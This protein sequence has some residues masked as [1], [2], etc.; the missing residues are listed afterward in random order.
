MI[1]MKDIL[2]V[3]QH[4]TFALFVF[5]AVVALSSI[6]VFYVWLRTLARCAVRMDCSL[7]VLCRVRMGNAEMAIC[8]TNGF[9]HACGAHLRM[10]VRLNGFD[11]G[12]ERR[13]NACIY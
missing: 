4:K 6:Y 11:K 9:R 13:L 3:A 7:Q 5:G 8:E 2:A 1:I 12:R 10:L